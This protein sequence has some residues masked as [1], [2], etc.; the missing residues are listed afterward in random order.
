MS[1]RL[2][3]CSCATPH[4][5]HGKLSC[6]ACRTQSASFS[7]SA[8]L[9]PPC[10]LRM[11]HH[12]GCTAPAPACSLWQGCRQACAGSQWSRTAMKRV[13]ARYFAWLDECCCAVFNPY[14]PRIGR[15]G[16]RRPTMPTPT[17]CAPGQSAF[18]C[19]EQLRA[20]GTASD[21][22]GLG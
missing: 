4:A 5:M 16:R 14:V 8:V 19:R 10:M 1:T 15:A 11:E 13:H 18:Y 22:S 12:G 6:A 20:K 9:L 3:P 2:Y 21:V 17:S 7:A